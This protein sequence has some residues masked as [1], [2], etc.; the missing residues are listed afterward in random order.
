MDEIDSYL[1]EVQDQ[2]VD[3]DLNVLSPLQIKEVQMDTFG[4]KFI[5]CTDQ[6][7]LMGLMHY[8]DARGFVI[9]S[10]LSNR[11]ENKGE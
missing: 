8:L 3:H 2:V 6:S 1:I 7:G 11:E 10:A 5:V 9:L 4:T